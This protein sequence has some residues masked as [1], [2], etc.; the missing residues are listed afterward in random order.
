VALIVDDEHLGPSEARWNEV[1]HHKTL[2][3]FGSVGA[4]RLVVVAPHPDDEVLGA[5]GLIQAALSEH[6]EVEVIAVT[7]GEASHPESASVA[8]RNL[9]VVRGD[10][11]LT[12]LERLG[13]T[14]PSITR[15]H[16]PDGKVSAHRDQLDRA[17]A[18]MLLPNDLCVAPWR[19]D[20]HPDHEVCGESAL[21]ANRSVGARAL[22][23]L[24]WA[25]HWA[26]P[27]GS[28]I[29][30]DRC[31]RLDLN[32]RAR[33]RKRWATAAFES[34]TRSLGPGLGDQAVLPAPLMRR[35]WRPYEVYV[36]E[37]ASTR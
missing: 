12:A 28:D 22:E 23:Y 21:K 25:W 11:S 3:L 4:R 5:G 19:R 34:Q 14:R 8:S 31:R 10:E 16:L 36:D 1:G 35:F 13:W 33:A 2:P 9:A 7:D 30:W 27:D 15:L 17:L 6:A 26:D 24:V 29:P 37:T 18:A 20:G 32:S